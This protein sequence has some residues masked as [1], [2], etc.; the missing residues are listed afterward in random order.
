MGKLIEGVWHADDKSENA[1]QKGR[2]VREDSVLRSWITPDGAPDPTGEGGFPAEAGRYH[3][4]VSITCPWAHRTWM[5]RSLKG[6]DDAIGLS[7]VRPRRDERGWVFDPDEE[8]FRDPVYGKEALH[9]I[10]TMGH[11][12]YTGRVT[13]PLLVDTKQDKAVSN[14]SSEIIRMLNSAFSGVAGNDRD[15][16]P[17]DLRDE[18]ETIN[19][20][21]YDT[22]NNGVYRAGFAQSQEAYEEAAR[23]IFATLDWLEGKLAQT[24]YVAGDRLTEAD[25]RLLPTLVRFDVAYHGHFK[26][27]LRRL[28]DYPNLWDY[29]RELVQMPEITPTIHPEVYKLGYYSKSAER[30]PFG[31]VPKGPEIDFTLPHGRERL[32][33]AA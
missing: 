13:V 24:R 6:L 8:R 12:D 22:L 17:A 29:T 20:R 14:E 32:P 33:A 2:W 7:L 21:V 18:I 10:Y 27:N 31:I 16:Y 26:C 11:T 3:I 9:E 19:K 1:V 23:E 30:N 4:Y 5:M 15:F 25:I 28:I